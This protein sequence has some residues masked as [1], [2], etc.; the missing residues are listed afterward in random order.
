MVKRCVAAGCS[1]TAMDGVHLHGFPKDLGLKKKWT[2]QVK[3]ARGTYRQLLHFK[4]NS[5]QP[6]NKLS[7]SLCLEK[8]RVLLKPD[9]IPTIFETLTLMKRKCEFS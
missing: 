8:V 7:Q 1:S 6:Y 4:E 2:D 3:Q 9:A 5:F